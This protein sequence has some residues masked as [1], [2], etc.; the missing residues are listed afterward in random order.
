MKPF[1]QRWD[2]IGVPG[3]LP[4]FQRVDD[5]H[6][7]DFYLGRDVTGEWILLLVTDRQPPASQHFRAIHVISRFRHDGRWA[8]MFQL[9]R[10]ELAKIFSHLCEDLVESSRT[11]QDPQK[12]VSFVMARFGRWQK[13]LERG[14]SGL[15]DLHELRGL[16]GELLFLEQ[17]AIPEHGI[18]AAISGWV[19]PQGAD[20]DFVFDVRRVEVKTARQGADTVRISS[21]EQLDLV[22]QPLSLAVVVLDDV[23]DTAGGDSFDALELVRR[24]RR[25]IESVPAVLEKFEDNL[26]SAGFLEREEYSGYRFLFYRIRLFGVAGEFPRIVRSR[27]PV[28]IGT[29]AYELRLENC[30]PFEEAPVS[31]L[32]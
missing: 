18:E 10:P 7:L 3:E 6:P 14:R 16:L 5:C 2:E 9:K 24:L 15:L 12:A 17:I 1:D 23:G 31:T 25:R 8:L 30:L 19:G 21:A 11:L 13:L 29:V 27:L 28:G 32:E 22:G 20:Q 26:L 4:A